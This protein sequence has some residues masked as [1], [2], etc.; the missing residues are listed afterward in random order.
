MKNKLVLQQKD[1]RM[2]AKQNSNKINCT[3]GKLYNLVTC[4]CKVAATGFILVEIFCQIRI[5]T[6]TSIVTV[7]FI[8]AT[9]HHDKSSCS[10][11][12]QKLKRF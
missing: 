6:I 1:K 10:C 5:T 12:V 8:N 4:I 7:L 2:S 9:P 11:P 3:G